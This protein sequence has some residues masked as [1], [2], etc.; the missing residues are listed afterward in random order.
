MKYRLFGKSLTLGI[1]LLFVGTAAP[2]SIN[3]DIIE[4]DN[5]K[6]DSEYQYISSIINESV[7]DLQYIYNVTENLSKI[8]FTEYNESS[9]EIA[10]GRDFGTKGEHKA[11]DILFENLTSLGIYTWKEP[12]N[13]TPETLSDVPKKIASKVEIMEKGL[14]IK[15]ISDWSIT[16]ISECY[17]SSRWNLTAGSIYSK[18][19]KLISL[20]CPVNGTFDKK[21]HFYNEERLTYNF[22]YTNLR[23]IIKPYRY[24]LPTEVLRHYINNE[25][26]VY[27]AKDTDYCK[28][29]EPPPELK[30]IGPILNIIFQNFPKPHNEMVLWTL[31]QP[32]CKGLILVDSN[33]DTFN[34][35]PGIF[36]PLPKIRINGS[37]GKKILDNPDDYRLDFYIN[38]Q[39]IESV[40]SYNVIGQINGTNPNET[41]IVSC[42]YDCEWNQ[43]TGDSA[44]GMATVLGVAKY[45]KEQNITPKCN[46]RFIGFCGEEHGLRGAYYYEVL[47]R[48]ENISMVIDLNQLGFNWTKTRLTLAVYTNSESLNSTVSDVA[49]RTDYVN[50]TGYV[51]NFTTSVR[52][53]GGPPSNARVFADAKEQINRSYNTILIVKK[54]P[55]YFHHK[56]GMNHQEGDVIKYFDWLDTSITGEMVWNVTKYFTVDDPLD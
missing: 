55:W 23:V 44:I 36:D 3:G 29:S 45:M 5:V 30:F 31:F 11:A 24:S 46:V 38:Q 43:G 34:E 27:I 8:I 48:N 51:T 52:S 4:T 20:L 13:N 42:L 49:N 10:K 25:P 41:V 17:F 7:L 16:P 15:K 35:G 22:S 40:E 47:H 26:F 50:R 56:D 19:A 21:F 39:W 12:I 6:I 2:P 18:T 28:W 9:G 53:D 32:N 37:I 14:V 54:G 1:I 33:N